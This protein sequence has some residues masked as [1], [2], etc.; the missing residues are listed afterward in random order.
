M[1]LSILFFLFIESVVYF[2]RLAKLK[3]KGHPLRYTQEETRK[4]I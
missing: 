3:N 1:F 2:F 4:Q